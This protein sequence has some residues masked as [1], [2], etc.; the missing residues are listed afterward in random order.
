[1]ITKGN[2][3][4]WRSVGMTLLVLGLFAGPALGAVDMFI[5][6]EGIPGES[7]DQNHKDWIDV[8]SFD[9]S[10]VRQPGSGAGGGRAGSQAAEASDLFVPKYID[11]A[12]PQ[13][14]LA[15]CEGRPIPELTL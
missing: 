6:I 15:C 12:R 3:H 2:S 13:L 9:K 1:M 8:L 14:V 11:K 5:K 7:Q 4:N 10:V